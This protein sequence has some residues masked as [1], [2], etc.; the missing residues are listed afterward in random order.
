[1]VHELGE[2]LRCRTQAVADYLR[3]VVEYV[4]AQTPEY[5]LDDCMRLF[6]SYFQRPATPAEARHCLACAAVVGFYWYVWSMFQEMQGNPMG[7]WQDI[8]RRAAQRFGAQ[9]LPSYRCDPALRARRMSRKEFDRLPRLRACDH[10]KERR[11]NAGSLIAAII[12]LA[13]LIF[14][15]A[16]SFKR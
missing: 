2:S 16:C 10:R 13:T 12:V 5:S 4:L 6:D 3:V 8:W 9:V 15:F 7:E 11:S 14:S 1:M